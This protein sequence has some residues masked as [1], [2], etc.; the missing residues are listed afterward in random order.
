MS[1][2]KTA[3]PGK[4]GPLSDMSLVA[5]FEDRVELARIYAED[6]A[7]VTAAKILRE[8]ADELDYRERCAN[9]FLAHLSSKGRMAR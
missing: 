5:I 3:A 1:A 2:P 8:V 6:G 7:I 9:A 4:P